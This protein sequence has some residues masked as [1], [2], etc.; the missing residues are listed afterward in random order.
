MNPF[1][2]LEYNKIKDILA[3]ECHSQ[4]GKELALKLQPLDEKKQIEYK[5]FLTAEVQDLIKN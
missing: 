4:L 1:K 3:K 2:Q 5:L